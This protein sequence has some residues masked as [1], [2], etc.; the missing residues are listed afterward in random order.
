MTGTPPQVARTASAGGC[1]FSEGKRIT[2]A[3]AVPG[4]GVESGEPASVL[5]DQRVGEDLP[6]QRRLRRQAQQD[7]HLLAKE[8]VAPWPNPPILQD[9]V[10]GETVE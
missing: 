9:H 7:I 1:S 5:L 2:S 3:L 8:V 6:R 10:D 4:G